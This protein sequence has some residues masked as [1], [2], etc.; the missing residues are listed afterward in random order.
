MVVTMSRWIEV[1]LEKATPLKL[2][3]AELLSEVW[4]VAWPAELSDTRS[5]FEFDR[6]HPYPISSS[7]S[8]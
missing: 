6:V 5:P 7:M 8:P 4:T 3:Q 2:E 1:K